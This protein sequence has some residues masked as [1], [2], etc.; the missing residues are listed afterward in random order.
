M[1]VLTPYL[2]EL[3]FFSVSVKWLLVSKQ[4]QFEISVLQNDLK[5]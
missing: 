1:F 4:K 3:V 2:F 5:C